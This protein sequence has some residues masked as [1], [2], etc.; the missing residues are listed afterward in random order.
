MER[1]ARTMSEPFIVRTGSGGPIALAK[2]TGQRWTIDEE[3]AEIPGEMD[4][5]YANAGHRSG[6]SFRTRP[7]GD[8]RLPDEEQDRS[9]RKEAGATI[10]GLI[11]TKPILGEAAGSSQ[12]QGVTTGENVGVVAQEEANKSSDG[13]MAIV[14]RMRQQL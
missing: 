14:A 7:Q 13:V 1:F 3:A 4:Y 11:G 9:R 6:T 12:A 8:P 5:S 2:G 10:R